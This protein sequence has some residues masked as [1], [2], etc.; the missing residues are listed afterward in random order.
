MSKSRDKVLKIM[1][2]SFSNQWVTTQEIA[3]NLN[4]SREVISLYLSQLKKKQLKNSW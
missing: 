2:E 1:R 3:D 4:L